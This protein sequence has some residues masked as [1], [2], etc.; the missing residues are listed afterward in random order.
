MTC[1]FH[2]APLQ[3]TGELIHHLVLDAMPHCFGG[4]TTFFFV[5]IP[6]RAECILLDALLKLSQTTDAVVQTS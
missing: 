4:T 2:F 1:Q 5:G 3:L 6:T